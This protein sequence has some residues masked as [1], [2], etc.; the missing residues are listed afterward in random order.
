MSYVVIAVPNK[1]TFHAWDGV[2]HIDVGYAKAPIILTV[3][4]HGLAVGDEIQIMIR[5]Q[6]NEQPTQMG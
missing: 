5:K 2:T 3:P 6:E 1:D 4:D